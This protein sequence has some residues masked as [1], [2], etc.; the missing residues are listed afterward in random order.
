VNVFEDTDGG[1]TRTVDGHIMR[2][3]GSQLVV[4]GGTVDPIHVA[5]F[6]NPCT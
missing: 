2:L 4:A 3:V 1:T 5:A 6:T